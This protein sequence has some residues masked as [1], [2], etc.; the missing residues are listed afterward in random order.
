MAKYR[1]K[2]DLSLKG[3]DNL[4]ND[5]KRYRDIELQNK[6][7]RA[8]SLLLDKGIDVANGRKGYFANFI[9]FKKQISRERYGVYGIMV[10][11]NTAPNVKVWYNSEG[12]QQAEISSILMAEFGSGQFADSTI[13][14]EQVGHRGTF[15]NQTHAFQDSWSF[16]TKLDEN[17]KPTGWVRTK[18]IKP[19]SPMYFASKEMYEE[20]VNVFRSVFK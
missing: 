17:G 6:M 4:I 9:A 1:L 13:N 11:F 10:G 7:E 5:L 8:I 14:I 19:T 18:G 2:E 12:E 20:I 15:P 3:I 16:A